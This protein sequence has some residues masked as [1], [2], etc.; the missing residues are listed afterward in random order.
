MSAFPFLR[1]P[2]WLVLIVDLDREGI[3]W[4]DVV[5]QARRGG[6][7]GLLI[8]SRRVTA[9]SL[10]S[11]I[12]QIRGFLPPEIMVLVND[13]IDVAR[14]ARLH[15]VHL[16]EQSFPIQT[17]RLFYPSAVVGRSLHD[18]PPPG[19]RPDYWVFGNVYETSSHPGRPPQGVHRLRQIVEASDIPVLAIGGI[20]EDRVRDVIRAGAMGVVVI[21]AIATAQN[22]EEATRILKA[23]LIEA[24]REAHDANPS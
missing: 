5:V 13:R 23:S 21:S 12:Q 20:R 14:I 11:F 18:L 22:P 24:W 17:A 3:D 10:L 16:P 2:P 15:G 8:R 1:P 19:P 6:I 4:K 7:D 9:G